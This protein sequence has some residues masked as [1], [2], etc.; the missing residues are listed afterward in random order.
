MNCAHFRGLTRQLA[1]VPHDHL[2]A[3]LGLLNPRLSCQIIPDYTEDVAS[4]FRKFAFAWMMFRG[5]AGLLEEAVGMKENN[6]GLPSWTPDFSDTK[7]DRVLVGA[8]FAVNHQLQPGFE[9]TGDGFGVRAFCLDRIIACRP[10]RSDSLFMDEYDIR[11]SPGA[12]V[13]HREWRKFFNMREVP[14]DEDMYVGGGTLED[15]Y[16]RTLAMERYYTQ[17]DAVRGRQWLLQE[18]IDACKRWL[19]GTL[20]SPAAV[21]PTDPQ[22]HAENYNARLS[23]YKNNAQLFRTR[24]GY[25]GITNSESLLH[26]NDSIFLIAT[27]ASASILRPAPSSTPSNAYKLVTSAYVHGTMV[28]GITPEESSEELPTLDDH[29]LTHPHMKLATS[30]E[31]IWLA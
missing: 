29:N 26:V 15:A 23:V 31:K 11:D 3:F 30:W 12:L 27:T 13:C 22:R 19:T 6:F 20:E 17:N 4:V 24:L 10:F 16:W 21:S 7:N 28:R 5:D 1:S 9:L 8:R 14:N 2:Y 18:H 25:I